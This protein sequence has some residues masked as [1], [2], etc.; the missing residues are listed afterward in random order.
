MTSDNN[1]SKTLPRTTTEATNRDSPGSRP[2]QSSST[3]SNRPTGGHARTPSADHLMVPERLDTAPQRKRQES[4]DTLRRHAHT[5]STAAHPPARTLPR[6]PSRNDSHPV[7]ARKPSRELPRTPKSQSHTLPAPTETREERHSRMRKLSSREMLYPNPEAAKQAFQAERAAH[8]PPSHRR[9]PTPHTSARRTSISVRRVDSDRS[10]RSRVSFDS[11]RSRR[12]NKSNRSR[13]SQRTDDSG[14]SDDVTIGDNWE[15]DHGVNAS[16]GPA[17]EAI[18]VIGLGRKTPRHRTFNTGMLKPALRSTSRVNSRANLREDGGVTPTLERSGKRE[19]LLP[20]RPMSYVASLGDTFSRLAPS[21]QKRSRHTSHQPTPSSNA[22]QVESLLGASASVLSRS[23]S[24]ATEHSQT[25]NQAGIRSLFSSLSLGNGNG[26]RNDTTSS[27]NQSSSRF[28]STQDLHQSHLA[29]PSRSS[30]RQDILPADDLYSYLKLAEVGSWDR[31]PIPPAQIQGRRGIW[32][33]RRTLSF[34]EM[35]WEWHRR[36]R[37]AEEARMAGRMLGSWECAGRSWEKSILNFQQENVPSHPIDPGNR[38]GTQIF[39][40]PAEG[41]DTL[42]FYD[43]A[44]PHAEDLGLLSWITGTLLQTAVSTLHMLRYSSQT[45]TFHLIPSPRPPHLPHSS[46]SLSYDSPD[47]SH[48]PRPHYLWEGFG[49]MVLVNKNN[50]VDRAMVLEIRPPSVVDSSVVKEFARGKG[51]EGWWAFYGETCVGDV[52]QA[53]LLQAQVYDSCI[54]NQVFFFAVTNLKYWVFG[55]FGYD[56]PSPYPQPGAAGTHANAGPTPVYPISTPNGTQ[57]VFPVNM[58]MGS[59]HM[60]Q[61]EYDNYGLP[62]YNDLSM[63]SPVGSS[64]SPAP[65][66]QPSNGMTPLGMNYGGWV[67]PSSTMGGSSVRAFSPTPQHGHAH[68]PT[69]VPGPGHGGMPYN[70]GTS[71]YGGGMF[72]W[73]GMR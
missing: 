46:S 52:G 31:W 49:T 62:S 8:P 4:L 65:Y 32:G 5:H 33:G 67:A 23:A 22:Y 9:P 6:P 61:P 27:F 30:R 17:G 2:T 24:R 51:G 35:G 3:A 16:V 60:M 10:I 20:S 26:N 28:G 54:Q 47:G 41:F 70:F 40:L 71:W 37:A 18:E 14:D 15:P 13:R 58:A 59:S 29:A 64:M 36:L 42:E 38:W 21:S 34:D 68:A 63:S 73:P 72:S 55:Q 43:E 50:D 57:T 53:N 19:K 11:T 66:A 39:A 48:G 25:N 45:F 69:P 56:Y 1:S 7:S 12:S 44:L